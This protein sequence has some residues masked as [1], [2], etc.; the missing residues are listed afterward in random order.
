M[1]YIAAIRLESLKDLALLP[2][3]TDLIDVKPDLGA[4]TGPAR[5][6]GG[7]VVEVSNPDEPY[8]GLYQTEI[9]WFLTHH[10]GTTMNYRDVSTLLQAEFSGHNKVAQVRATLKNHNLLERL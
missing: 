9:D 4:I 6:H 2:E 5:W 7:S 3:G 10:A 8:T 1:G